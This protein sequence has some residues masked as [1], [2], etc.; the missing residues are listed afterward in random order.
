MCCVRPGVRD[1]KASRLCCASVLMAVDLPALLRPTKA[2]SGSSVTG[3][4]SSWLDVVMKRAVCNQ[5]SAASAAADSGARAVARK[6]DVM[7]H[8][9]ILRFEHL[10]G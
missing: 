7:G 1:A 8:C 4:W 9:K 3:N 5:A 2:I 6:V 10:H